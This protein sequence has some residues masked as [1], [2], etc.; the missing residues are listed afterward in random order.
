MFGS[1]R[2]RRGAAPDPNAE[3]PEG[4]LQWRRLISYLGPH[5]ARM[6]LAFIGL[7]I[8]AATS[9]VFPAL[10]STVIDSVLKSNNAD[11]LNRITAALIAVFLLSSIARFVEQYYLNYIGEKIVTDLRTQLYSHLQSLSLGF[12]I[13]RRVPRTSLQRSNAR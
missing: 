2:R 12:F 1:R 4:P 5:K 3:I 9:L 11:L 8:S 10:I 7:V 13:R 6:G